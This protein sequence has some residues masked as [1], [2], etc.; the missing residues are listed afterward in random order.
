[1]KRTLLQTAGIIGLVVGSIASSSVVAQTTANGPYYATPSWDQTLPAATRFIVLTNFNSEAVLDRETGLVWE[2]S[3]SQTTRD[4]FDSIERCQRLNTGGRMGWRLPAISELN[5]LVD[6]SQSSPALPNGH[7]FLGVLF[8]AGTPATGDFVT[9]SY[10]S[11]TTR[12]A[13]NGQARAV[14]FRQGTQGDIAKTVSASP[15]FFLFAWCV[16]GGQGVDPQ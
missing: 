13:N 6:Q 11:G 2:R 14:D 7:P 16:R 1:M 15:P 5:S 9:R 8:G 3:P 12:A 4:W 10:Y